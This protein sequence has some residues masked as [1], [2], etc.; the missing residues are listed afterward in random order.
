MSFVFS[1]IMD[2]PNPP[3]EREVVYKICICERTGRVFMTNI[4][5]GERVVP[6]GVP[7]S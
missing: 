6:G 3:T 4:K 1:Q 2:H 7:F 5:T